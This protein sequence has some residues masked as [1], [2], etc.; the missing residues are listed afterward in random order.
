MARPKKNA[1]AETDTA[2]K[3]E[4]KT[5]TTRKAAKVEVSTYLQMGASEWD[6]SSLKERVMEAAAAGRK[7]SEIKTLAIYLKPEEGKIYYTANE[8]IAGSIDL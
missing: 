7:A 3:P 8:D 4:K 6:I 1:A 2:T 5:A